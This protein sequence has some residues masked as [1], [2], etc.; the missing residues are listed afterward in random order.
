MIRANME[1][2]HIMLQGRPF[3][4]TKDEEGDPFKATRAFSLEYGWQMLG[5]KEW[6]QTCKYPRLGFGAEYMRVMKRNE[7]GH[8]FSVYAFY[9]GNYIRTKNFELTNRLAFGLA[10]GFK[11]FDPDDPA[12]NDIFCTSLNVFAE[13]GVGMALRLHH[14]LY[15]E[16]GI[17]LTHFSNGNTREP[18]KGLNIPSFTIG[19]RTT[20]G[21][22]P[23]EPEKVPLSQCLHRHEVLA[24]LAMFPRQLDFIDDE[25][26]LHETYGL[27]FLMANLHLGYN[28]ELSRRIKLGGGVDLFFDGTNG[29]K[30]ASLVVPGMPQK[31][32]VPLRDKTG[33]AIFVGGESTI[34]RLSVVISLGYIVARSH[35]ESSTPPLE[36][37]LGIKY[38]FLPDVF[39]GANVRAYNF[40][41][42]KAVELNIGVRRFL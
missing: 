41:A 11:K 4:L 25:T 34:Q 40:R 2:G 35:F 36:Q 16:P 9:D 15:L 37:R 19:L 17:R 8:P 18:Q 29:M 5:G 23:P 28:Y 38:H 39:A 21:N 33:V 30:E 32:E 26:R 7:L 1:N 27:H 24:F 31:S 22:P 3:L 6:H 12:S 42:A 10:Y 13:L 20:L 14:S